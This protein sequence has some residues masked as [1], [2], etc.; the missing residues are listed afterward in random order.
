MLYD[1]TGR[2]I[3]DPPGYE[4]LCIMSGASTF[5]DLLNSSG[6]Q[7]EVIGYNSLCDEPTAI[8]PVLSEE[9]LV[10]IAD[11]ITEEGVNVEFWLT[12]LHDFRANE[13]WFISLS[14]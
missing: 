9:A 7:A 6:C 10:S 4:D 13:N 11:R 12:F 14:Y 1:R 3:M 8:R 2:W 5:Y